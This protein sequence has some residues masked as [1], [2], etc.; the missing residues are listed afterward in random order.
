MTWPISIITCSCGLKTLPVVRTWGSPD[1]T[2]TQPSDGFRTSICVTVPGF[3]VSHISSERIYTSC[4]TD[5]CRNSYMLW[6]ENAFH[7]T[8]YLGAECISQGKLRNFFRDIPI[9]SNRWFRQL[10]IAYDSI[11][12]PFCQH[13]GQR[14]AYLTNDFSIP[15]SIS[16]KIR[17]VGIPFTGI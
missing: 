2:V 4:S 16:W 15:F 17:Y 9:K 14:H 1:H 7:N 13:N 3:S 8:G 6:H 5:T 10:W 12:L 11:N